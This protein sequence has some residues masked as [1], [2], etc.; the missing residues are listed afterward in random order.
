MRNSNNPAPFRLLGF[1]IEDFEKWCDM[2][3][4]DKRAKSSKKEFFRLALRY[5]IVK[6]K[7]GE[8]VFAEERK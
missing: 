1:E 2:K 5:K 6:K 3:G 8:M 4:L 7:N